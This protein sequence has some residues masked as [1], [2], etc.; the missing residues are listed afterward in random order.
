MTDMMHEN[1]FV[2]EYRCEYFVSKEMKQVWA[3]ELDLYRVFERACR[4]NNLTYYW[5]YGN[6][7]G[8]A[9]HQGFIPWD[10]DIDVFLFRKDYE[11][12]CSIAKD[13]FK[14]PYFFQ[15]EHTDPGAHIAFSKLRNCETSAILDFE[16]P[17]KYLYNQGI[18]LDI[19]PIDNVPDNQNELKVLER[20]I[21]RIKY[22]TVRW[23]RIFDS[24]KFYFGRR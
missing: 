21:K 16:R 18:F 2:E 12:L 4:A 3:A 20:K 10:D 1:F 6:L 19:F 14:Y 5:A 24:R 15:N 23:A 17:Y 9:R 13:V 11:K 22:R 7:L 8:A